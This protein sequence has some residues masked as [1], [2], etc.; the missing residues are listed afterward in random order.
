MT[1]T[2]PPKAQVPEV[3]D[4]TFLPEDFA[5]IAP[6]VMAPDRLVHRRVE[7]VSYSDNGETRR[8]ISLDLTV[9]KLPNERCGQI[10]IPIAMLEKR[11][12]ARF[13]MRDDSG[14]SVPVL[15]TAA[16]AELS[17]GVLEYLVAQ[18][19][20]E[21]SEEVH[22]SLKAAISNP[23]VESL[24]LNLHLSHGRAPTDEAHE[25]R[26]KA[27]CSLA[28]DLARR[29][30]LYAVF[31]SE[32][33]GQRQV[34]KFSYEDPIGIVRL[35]WRQRLLEHVKRATPFLKS[36]TVLSQR[37][38]VEISEPH[39]S[40]AESFH[41][42]VLAPSGLAAKSLRIW[43]NSTDEKDWVERGSGPII[44][45]QVA[46]GASGSSY[47]AYV[48]L[49]PERRGLMTTMLIATLSVAFGFWA[50][51]ALDEHLVAIAKDTTKVAAASAIVLVVPAFFFAFVARG[52]EHVITS[53]ILR[54]PRWTLLL[55]SILLV[56]YAM[57]LVMGPSE[58]F[59]G[60]WAVSVAAIQTL[61]AGCAILLFRKSVG[62]PTVSGLE[63]THT[64]STRG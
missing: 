34:V 33:R 63:S 17:F 8:H 53:R 61:L 16:N 62:G 35:G 19:F 39:V 18:E 58:E 31:P 28:D 2:F 6:L 25:L 1:E 32:W 50:C 64:G 12:L 48:A 37:G 55:T 21:V 14:R 4:A 60:R 13:D 43:R 9:P 5:S 20:G 30:V 56:A 47:A 52:T 15:E 3:V 11:V 44:H 51:V 41:L 29:F 27:V 36:A 42:E 40:S 57:V 23:S 10:V 45:A 49:G 46:D 38:W 26:Q 24:N 7:T 22:R 59:L 54:P